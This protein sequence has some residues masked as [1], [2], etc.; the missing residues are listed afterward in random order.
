[1]AV[2]VGLGIG[3]LMLRTYLERDSRF[4][5]TGTDA[6]Q[7]A[8]LTE[9]SRPEMLSVFGEDVGRNVFF[10]PLSE[11]RRQLEQL[12]WVEHASVM[13]LLPDRIRVSVVERKP[14]AFT[15]H[16]NEIG[17]VDASGVLL[18]MPASAMA[19]HHYSFPVLTGIDAGDTAAARAKRMAVYQ[20]LMAELGTGGRRATEQLSE[21]DLTDPEDARVTMPEQGGDILAH[22]G[23]D[24]FLE[25]YERYRTHIA[26]WKQQYP[27]LAS[28]DL[29]YD[30]QVVLEMN[31]GKGPADTAA[32]DAS[33]G[34]AQAAEVKTASTTKGKP[35]AMNKPN[36]ARPA[37]LAG[38]TAAKQSA[39]SAA[40][41]S[42]AAKKAALSASKRK[43]VKKP[44]KPAA[45]SKRAASGAMIEY[46][47]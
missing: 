13:R 3:V 18:T 47:G 10:I 9:V 42:L 45:Q 32:G 44:V 15:R 27:H 17:L 35:S 25:R 4:R 20:R 30:Q 31:P 37:K 6:I 2:L 23:D 24:R 34:T 8:G 36:L 43:T 7:A 11:R 19:R 1:M 26:E 41:K 12:A 39:A 46:G 21:I 22:F 28:V 16:G 29:R 38:G 14:V 5:I 40:K 33:A